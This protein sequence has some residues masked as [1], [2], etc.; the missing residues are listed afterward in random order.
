MDEILSP[1]ELVEDGFTFLD[2][3]QMMAAKDFAV[4]MEDL[5][6]VLTKGKY[7]VSLRFVPIY[8][9]LLALDY[10][11]LLPLLRAYNEPGLLRKGDQLGVEESDRNA[12]IIVRGYGR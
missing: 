6:L 7:F 9:N 2:G 10:P 12:G 5:N 8:E 3:R 1:S 4:N 11:W